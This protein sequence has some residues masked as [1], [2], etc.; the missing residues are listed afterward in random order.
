MI[1]GGIT[2]CNSLVDEGREV[3]KFWWGVEDEGGLGGE[4]SQPATLLHI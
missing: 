2:P 3:L 4:V 1:G